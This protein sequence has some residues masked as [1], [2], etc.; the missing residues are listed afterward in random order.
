MKKGFLKLAAVAAGLVLMNASAAMAAGWVDAGGSWQYQMEDGSMAS[1]G[2]MELDGNWY[3]FNKNGIMVTGWHRNRDTRQLY[4]LNGDGTLAVDTTLSIDGTTYRADE[5]GVCTELGSY[6]GWLDDENGRW[7]RYTNGRYP[8]SEW[9]EV[10]GAWYRFGEDGYVKTG[11][12]EENGVKYWLGAD[13]IMA[14]DGV[15]DIEGTVYQFDGSGAATVVSSY[16]APTVI[17]DDA[18][19]TAVHLQLD[20]MADQI[21]AGIVNDTMTQTQKA[22]AIYKWV[23]GNIRYV[24]T[25]VKGDWVQ[26]AYDGIRRKKGDC[27]TYYSVS[28]ELLSRVGIPSI[29]V[30]RSDGHHWWNLIDCGNGW[31]HFDTCPRASGGEFCLLTDAQIAAYSANHGNSHAY[32]HSLYPATPLQ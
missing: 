17:P 1:E 16:K 7:Y 27:Y 19:K 22:Q 8:A 23:R 25:S 12:Y 26:A 30:V 18:D 32:D 6:E 14:K 13:G 11:W 15:L 10:D 21:L 24:N 9:K 28:L 2:W 20:Q 29:E 4:W 5:N 31:Y 3:Y